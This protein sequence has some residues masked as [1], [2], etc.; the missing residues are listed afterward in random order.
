MLWRILDNPQ[1]GIAMFAMLILALSV[2]E[3]AHAWMALKRGDDTAARMGR[4]TLNPAAHLDPMGLMFIL[5]ATI[6][7]GKPVPV[8]PLNLKDVRHDS[9]YIALAGPVSNII[10][11]IFLALIFRL[12]NFGFGDAMMQGPSMLKTVL[13]ASFLVTFYGVFINLALAFFNLI[14]LFPLDGEKILGGILPYKQAIKLEQIRQHSMMILL[15]I[16]VLGMV[17]NIHVLGFYFNLVVFPLTNTMLG[18]SIF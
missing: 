7:W 6:G 15:G 17:F 12:L 3:M 18:V 16:I 8:N 2:H 10:Q 13:N 4:L 9:M 14:P 5:M 11:A 1:A